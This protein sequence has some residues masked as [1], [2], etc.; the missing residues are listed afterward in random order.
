M[1]NKH[2]LRG[3]SWL[4]KRVKNQLHVVGRAIWSFIVNRFYDWR[5]APS[6]SSNCDWLLQG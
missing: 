1:L 4:Y 5:N 6:S 3:L 2:Y